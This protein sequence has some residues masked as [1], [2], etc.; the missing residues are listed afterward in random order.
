MRRSAVGL[1]TLA[2]LVAPVG[3]A[4]ASLRPPT[5][6]K[7]LLKNIEAAGDQCLLMESGTFSAGTMRQ[8]F[9]AQDAEFFNPA[10]QFAAAKGAPIRVSAGDFPGIMPGRQDEAGMQMEGE[11]GSDEPHIGFIFAPANL[12]RQDVESVLGSPLSYVK[13][14]A[15][16][17]EFEGTPPDP[18]YYQ[19]ERT[20]SRCHYRLKVHFLN[21]ELNEIF[22]Q[23]DR[24]GQ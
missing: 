11:S 1:W 12:G 23:E 18:S 13:M 10:G 22:L 3:A 6:V 5:S 15:Y 16:M 7:E 4:A 9:G 14:P 21:N 8:L 17:P 20:N 2:I 19:L 24:P